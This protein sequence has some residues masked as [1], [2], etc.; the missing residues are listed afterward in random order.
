MPSELHAQLISINKGLDDVKQVFLAF[1]MELS[2]KPKQL[3][4]RLVDGKGQ[5]DM[6]S[7]KINY[8]N[9]IAE[10]KYNS[11]RKLIETVIL[12]VA[13][14]ISKTIAATIRNQTSKKRIKN[15]Y[16]EAYSP[17]QDPHSKE[18]VVPEPPPKQTLQMLNSFQMS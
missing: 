3:K 2:D 9:K 11:T 14:D 17:I 16:N 5:R 7:S 18:S 13:I 4:G 1:N 10:I 6:L 8:R 15:I 12:P